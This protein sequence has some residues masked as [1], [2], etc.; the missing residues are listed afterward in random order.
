MRADIYSDCVMPRRPRGKQDDVDDDD[1]DNEDPSRRPAREGDAD[2]LGLAASSVTLS[3][4]LN[5]IDGVASQVRQSLLN[6]DISLMTCRNTQSCSL[7]PTTS[8][9][10]TTP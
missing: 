8:K 2:R 7:R 9:G 6:R 4:L 5:A 1:N 3:G 10:W